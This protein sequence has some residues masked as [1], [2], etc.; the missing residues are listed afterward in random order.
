[1]KRKKIFVWTHWDLD[2]LVSCLVVKW[3]HPDCDFEYQPVGS[4]GIR[5]DIT[6]WLLKHKFEDYETVY[7]VDLDV[8]EHADLVD[9]KNVF[10]VDHHKSHVEKMKY[11]KAVAVVKEYPSACKLLYK[12]FKKLYNTPFTDAQKMLIIL[13]NDY[14]SYKHDLPESKMLNAIFWQTQKSF[15]TGMK[16]YNSG[17]KGFTQQQLAIYDIYKKDLDKALNGLKIF[18]NKSIEVLNGVYHVTATFT[19]S[20]VN[21]ITDYLLEKYNPDIAIVVNLNTKHVSFRR[22]KKSTVQLHTLAE[23]IADGGG[24]EYSA[25]GFVTD[26]FMEFTKLLTPIK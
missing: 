12:V 10:I 5:E 1:M 6:K 11:E 4:L 24:H 2:G 26:E 23:Q 21:D 16:L 13:G 9:R 8:S 7:F 17:F 25:G 22:N 19:D 18:E 15:D 3:A 14:D 20:F